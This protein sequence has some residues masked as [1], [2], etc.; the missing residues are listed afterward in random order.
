[1]T[2][3]ITGLQ[4][5]GGAGKSTLICTLA[6][7]LAEDNAKVLIVDTDEQKSCSTWVKSNNFENID[8]MTI[9]NEQELI[10]NVK[11]Y[12]DQYDVVLIDTAGFDSRIAL[13]A[14]QE[15]DLI[16][17]P[18]GGDRYSLEGASRTFKHA[19]Y[20]TENK[21]KQPHIRLIMWKIKS[22][23]TVYHHAKE[24]LNEADLP[25]LKCEVPHLTGFERMSWTGGAPDGVA[26][27]AGNALLASLQ[28][29][30]L[31]SYYNKKEESKEVA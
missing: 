17:I 29:D 22:N 10:E 16:L 21:V 4:Q 12:K 8:F 6:S 7:L 26:K 31:L 24:M 13:Y 28:M 1:M 9:L 11:A 15:S 3:V 25:V 2:Q 18:T 30:G 20:M 14:I 19:V 5:K 23:T 27:L